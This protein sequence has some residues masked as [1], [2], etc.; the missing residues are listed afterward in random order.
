MFAAK[1]LVTIII[2]CYN[3]RRFIGQ[4]LDSIIAN[5]FPKEQLEVLVVDGMSSDGT[6]D[7]VAEYEQR[8][9][10]IRMLDNPSRI[11]PKALNLGIQAARGE[12]I[13]RMDAHAYYETGYIAKC[14]YYLEK[15]GADNVG[16]VRRTLPGSNTLWARAIARSISHPFAAGNATYRIGARDMKW[17]DTVFGGCYRRVLFDEIGLFNETL[18]RGQDR[19]FNVR[20]TQNGGKILFVPD[21]VCYYYARDSLWDFLRWMYVGG[22]T[23]FYVSRIVG[24]RIFSW[25]NLVPLVFVLT[26]IGSL[27]LGLFWPWFLRVF[28]V[29][30]LVYLLAAV[31]SSLNIVREEGDIRFLLLMPVVFA[32]THLA[33]GLGSLVGLLKPVRRETIWS[34]V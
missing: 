22:L 5:D 12:I 3:E 16:G 2:P 17:V 13:I 25:R 14:V 23:P 11:K 6:R 27:V 8:Y 19:E 31:V 9:P 1:P 28:L 10:F 26:L 7:I 21:I 32:M 18:I 24:R 34:G 29:V 15:Y 4:C 33:Y 20:L 30:I